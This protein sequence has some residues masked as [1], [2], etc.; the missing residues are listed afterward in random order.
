MT[1]SKTGSDLRKFFHSSLRFVSK[2]TFR[3]YTLSYFYLQYRSSFRG[4]QG[5]DVSIFQINN[6]LGYCFRKLK[7]YMLWDNSK[8]VNNVTLSESEVTS[9]Y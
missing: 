4:F 8:K 6:F 3:K 9:E 1:S 7:V 2:G 5:S